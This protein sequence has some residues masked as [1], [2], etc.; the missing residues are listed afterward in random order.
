MCTKCKTPPHKFK[1]QNIFANDK[2]PV[3]IAILDGT[4]DKKDEIK[5]EEDTNEYP[6]L[7]N[8]QQLMMS[9]LIK[10]CQTSTT[11]TQIS[12]T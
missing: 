6:N 4:Y 2:D 12:L 11:S 9:S 3:E 5:H 7:R 8:N 1:N 10:E